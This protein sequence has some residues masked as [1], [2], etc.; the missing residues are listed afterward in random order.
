MIDFSIWYTRVELEARMR[1]NR[2]KG[3]SDNLFFLDFDGVINTFPKAFEEREGKFDV[4]N[5]QCVANVSRLCRER[6]MDLVI[7]SSWRYDGLDYCLDYLRSG[8]LDPSIRIRGATPMFP[9][10]QGREAE[11]LAYLKKEKNLTAFII[12]DDIPMHVLAPYAVRTTWERGLDE[13]VYNRL[14]VLP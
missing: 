13:D 9:A 12:A 2:Q 7:T 14:R 10:G 8:G 6:K 3:L 4:L 1:R 11:I 5:R